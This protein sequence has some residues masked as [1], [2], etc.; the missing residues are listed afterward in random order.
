MVYFEPEHIPS[1]QDTDAELEEAR[2][3]LASLEA[4]A[5]PEELARYRH[6]LASREQPTPARPPTSASPN[7]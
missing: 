1:A 4:G 3:T 6:A 7:R 5:A 2:H